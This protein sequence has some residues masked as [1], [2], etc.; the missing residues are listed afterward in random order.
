MNPCPCGYQ[1]DPTAECRC[2][3]EQIARYQGRISGPLLD[4]IDLF[5]EV[6]RLTAA[7]LRGSEGGE[8]SNA[9]RARVVATRERQLNRDGKP[10]AALS[11]TELDTSCAVDENGSRLLEQAL[12][13]LGLSA[14][15]YHRCLRV[16]RTIADLAASETIQTAHLAE[17]IGYRHRLG[18]TRSS[19]GARH[20]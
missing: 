13:R 20:A 10:A 11:P 8:P 6:P 17:A 14:R 15:A 5:M 19:A 2:T 12:E 1:G 3:P 4:R 9:V 16:A 18:P 7:E